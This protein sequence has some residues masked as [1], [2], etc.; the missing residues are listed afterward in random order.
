M[1]SARL[2]PA[3]AVAAI[4]ALAPAPLFAANADNPDGNVDRS[5]DAGN[6]TGNAGVEDLNKGQLDAPPRTAPAPTREETRTRGEA[7]P[8]R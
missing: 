2:V 1:M 3:L 8:P 6:S 5:N 7:P 4:L